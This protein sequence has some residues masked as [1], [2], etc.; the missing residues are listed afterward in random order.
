MANHKLIIEDDFD[1]DFALIAIHCAVED[2]KMAYLCN[3]SLK[4]MLR[5]KRVDLDFSANGLVVT[6]PWFAYEDP[7]KYVSYDL[8]KN[9]CR[10]PRAWTGT[11]GGLF[12][13]ET[14]SETTTCLL[15][16]L[17]QVDFLLKISTDGEL[18]SVKPLINGLKQINEV[19]S[20]Y[21]VDIS[22][23]KS[24]NNIIFD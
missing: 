9:R 11:S 7:K 13:E 8:L 1:K 6:F 21:E 24:I 5:R 15:P 2:Y 4:F 20:A 18:T 16:E 12:S 22:G 17:R 10:S 23:L 14:V 3:R 19:V